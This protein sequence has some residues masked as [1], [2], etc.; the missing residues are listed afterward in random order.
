M[1]AADGTQPVHHPELIRRLDRRDEVHGR[2]CQARSD[3]APPIGLR[4]PVSQRNEALALLRD[5]AD[6][7]VWDAAPEALP[8]PPRAGSSR[9]SAR[10]GRRSR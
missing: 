9:R 7:V 5:H 1:T 2:D 8:E 10:D 6:R 3:E 4:L